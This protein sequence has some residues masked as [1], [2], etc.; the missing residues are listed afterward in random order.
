MKKYCESC[1]K[2][3]Q[4]KI[5]KKNEVYVVC[6]EGIEVE[7][8]VLVCAE[9]G[10]EL[11]CEELDSATLKLAYDTYRRKHKLLLPEE[12]KAIRE[13]YGLSQRSFAKLLNWG[14]KT[15][16][17]YENGA[18]QDRA[19]NS[20]L[21]LLRKPEN[22]LDYILENEVTLGEKKKEK[23]IYTIEHMENWQT[24][25]LEKYYEKFL[26]IMPLDFLSEEE[27]N[28]IE[29]VLTKIKTVK[30]QMKASR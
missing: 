13:M 11:F 27:K 8:Q 25:R 21:R 28:L 3:T 19:H 30:S 14:E 29:Q 23:L 4:T 5:I 18:L 24:E 7:A 26:E 15:I 1:R 16:Y 20:L 22:M 6:G 17:R 2:E 12:I 9:C 10:E